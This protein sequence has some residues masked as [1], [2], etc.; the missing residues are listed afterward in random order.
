[1]NVRIKINYT[2]YVEF[3]EN[4]PD[5]IRAYTPDCV[6]DMIKRGRDRGFFVTY[7]H[8]VWTLE[9]YPVYMSYEGMNA[10]EIYNNCGYVSGYDEYVPAVYDAMLRGGKRLYCIA[11][12][13]NHNSIERFFGG[14]VMIKADK[15]E[16]STI[17]KALCDG[18]FYSSRGPE[19]YELW[20]EDGKVYITC[21]D[22]KMI[23]M[24]TSRRRTKAVYGQNGK[25]V[26]EA[27]FEVV[28]EDKYIR[29]TV[30]DVW[31]NTANTNAYFVD[32]IL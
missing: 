19:I 27:V 2:K 12:D 17:T 3:D 9:E 13:D 1:M 8:P 24:V 16:Y 7:N 10:M 6:N 29:L 11:A 15:L 22:A 5:Y 28:P 18:N 21:S 30:T 4:E 26:T 31:G 23:A 32:S 14:Y 25:T 20:V